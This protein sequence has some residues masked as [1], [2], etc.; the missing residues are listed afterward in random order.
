[1]SITKIMVQKFGGTSVANAEKI[2][3]AARRAIKAAHAGNQVVITVSAMGKTTDELVALA[4]EIHP[5]PPRRE[6]DVLLSTGEQVCCA[7]VN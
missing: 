1:M 7:N 5:N 2:N 6:M 3:R 4:G